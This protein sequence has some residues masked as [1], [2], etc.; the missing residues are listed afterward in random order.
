MTREQIELRI[1]WVQEQLAKATHPHD[2]AALNRTLERL[3]MAEADD[4]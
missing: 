2:I 3:V 4:E 1:S